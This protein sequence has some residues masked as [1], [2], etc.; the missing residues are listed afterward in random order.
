MVI[1]RTTLNAHVAGVG[2]VLQKRSAQVGALLVLASLFLSILL[3]PDAA[4]SGWDWLRLW[5]A[6]LCAG[7]A[8]LTLH[9]SLR[10]P[11]DSP[12]RQQLILLAGV[13]VIIGFAL[14]LTFSLG[15][16]AFYTLALLVAGYLALFNRTSNSGRDSGTIIAALIPFWV[17]SALD[18][19]SPGLLV[20]LPLLLVGVVVDG[21]M[22][23]ATMPGQEGDPLSTRGH[24]LAAWLGVLGAAL[25][26]GLLSLL[27]SH[28]L[29]I[30]ALA[31]TGAVI[32]IGLEAA[33]PGPAEG[34]WRVSSVAIV[35]AAMAW[36]ALCW[37]AGLS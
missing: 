14:N 37:L 32:L 36:I 17:W 8:L 31:G 10:A 24:R 20:L 30:S 35:D 28:A 19:W 27:T 34:S 22:R 9:L 2:Q 15:T 16:T 1:D 7:S 4:A 6:A 21:H 3:A 13:L 23:R 33:T 25:V 29:A 5:L 18:A 26:I 11:D 12:E